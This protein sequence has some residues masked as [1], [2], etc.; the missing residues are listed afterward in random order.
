MYNK[1][2][3]YFIE[4]KFKDINKFSFLSAFYRDKIVIQV[5]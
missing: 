5:Y 1:F 2:A 4:M 3:Q